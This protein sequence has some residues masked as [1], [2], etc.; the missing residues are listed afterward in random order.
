MS[1]KALIILAPGFEDLEAVTVIDLLRRAKIQLS[2]VC[3]REDEVTGSRGTRILADASLALLPRSPNFD[4]I[5]LP[6]GQPGADNL[7]ADKRVIQLIQTQAQAGRIVAAICAAPKVL[8]AAGLTQGKRIT[9]FPGAL[10]S[11]E[12]RDAEVTGAPV[13]V[14]GNLITGRSP[15][16][17]ID[18]ALTLVEQ[19]TDRD[20]R[21]QV[22]QS[23]AR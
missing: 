10:S 4:A 15:G 9:H 3:L 13:E 12:L 6:G 2:I 21:D 7:A 11:H 19:L 17:A 16:T 20:T 8:S 23:L 1:P 18:F 5:I 14:D 22:E